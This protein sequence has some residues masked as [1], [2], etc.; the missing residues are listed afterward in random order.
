MTFLN[1]VTWLH[2][3]ISTKCN[4]WC[5]GCPRNLNGFGLNQNLKVE[6]I[7]YEKFV[8]VCE[9]LPK[10]KNIQFCG[11]FGD[12]I[13]H[14]DP[15]KIFEYCVSKD[16]NIQIHTNGS[17][18]TKQWWNELAKILSESMHTIFFAIDGLSD[19]HHIHR[20]GTSFEKVIENS[21][22]FIK[23]NGNAVWQFIPY[24]HNE[25]QILPAIKMSQDLGFSKFELIKKPRDLSNAKHFKTGELLNIQHWSDYE[26]FSENR[27]SHNTSMPSCMHLEHPSIYL[28]ASGRISPC[29]FLPNVEFSEEIDIAEEL[30]TLPRLECKKNCNY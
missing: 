28:N 20:Q 30:K 7:S 15:K 27:T 25:H 2:A 21:L 23:N 24:K 5:P 4:A 26:R 12:P 22:E 8:E 29:C 19:T 10:L 9:S 17:L 3:E 16:Y 18:K 11:N 14:K 13:A 1:T 6:D